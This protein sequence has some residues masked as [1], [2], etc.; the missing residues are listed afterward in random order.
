MAELSI[1][2]ARGRVRSGRNV[3]P[4]LAGAAL[5]A[6]GSGLIHTLLPLRLV[7]AGYASDQIGWVATGFSVGFLAGCISNTYL[8]RSV[9]HVRA[10][11]VSAAFVAI[12]ILAYDW[13]P[14][15]L[16]MV[17]LAAAMGHAASGLSVVTES[18][19]NEL[20]APEWRGGC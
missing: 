5:A 16:V 7:A 3:V 9:G 1:P 14:P 8:I 17:V 11:G 10:Y 19:L 6:C 4:P 18:W 2:V 12:S 20:S 13:Q 15:L